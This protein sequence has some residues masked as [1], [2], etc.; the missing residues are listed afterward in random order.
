MRTIEH[1]DERGR[2]Y[3]VRLPD[4][5]PD[6]DADLGIIL[7]PPDV[8][9]EL[10]LPEPFATRLHNQLYNRGLYTLSDVRKK[11]TLL[12]GA[13]MAAVGVDAQLL[14]QAYQNSEKEVDL[15]E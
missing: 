10:E 2:K 14:T 8:V 4:H 12:Q 7:G 9:D 15:V 13:I 11:R 1:T 3:K 5:A 6:E